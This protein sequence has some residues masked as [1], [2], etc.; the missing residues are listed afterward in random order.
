MSFKNC[1]A[2]EGALALIFDDS[3]VKGEPE[4]VILSPKNTAEV[5]D[6]EEIDKN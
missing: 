6:T 3:N 4:I 5:F 1:P 2:F